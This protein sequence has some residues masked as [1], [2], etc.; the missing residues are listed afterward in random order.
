MAE[1]LGHK[2]G[3]SL[4]REVRFFAYWHA[5]MLSPVWTSCQE[6]P[7]A[8]GWPQRLPVFKRRLST[9]KNMSPQ[10]ESK[11]ISLSLPLLLFGI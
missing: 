4:L 9:L 10:A 5:R 2:N 6:L 7:A 1:T 8:V 11:P 3:G